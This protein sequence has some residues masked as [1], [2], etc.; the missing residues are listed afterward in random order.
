MTWSYR[1]QFDH[2]NT[3]PYTDPIPYTFN[4]KFDCMLHRL[5]DAEDRAL[6]DATQAHTTQTANDASVQALRA[7]FRA[8]Q[9]A[10]T[11]EVSALEARLRRTLGITAVDRRTLR[12]YACL[13][14]LSACDGD[15]FIS[16]DS[17]V[18]ADVLLTA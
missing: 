11:E 15:D 1:P 17:G 14:I 6:T 5:Q 13:L 18:H 2:V 10:K 9:V 8:Y 4:P 12:R 3:I 7:Q 16:A